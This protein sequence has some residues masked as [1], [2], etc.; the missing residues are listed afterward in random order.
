VRTGHCWHRCKVD[1]V[2]TLQKPISYHSITP[3]SY[4]AYAFKSNLV[5]LYICDWNYHWFY[6]GSTTCFSAEVAATIGLVE[7]HCGYGSGLSQ[8]QAGY[9]LLNDW[10]IGFGYQQLGVDGCPGLKGNHDGEGTNPSPV[11]LAQSLPQGGASSSSASQLPSSTPASAPPSVVASAS[12]VLPS[13]SL[14]AVAP[15][16][17]PPNVSAVFSGSAVASNVPAASS[18][19]A[20]SSLVAASSAPAASSFAS[21]S[22]S[23]GLL[24]VGY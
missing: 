6:T 8:V 1:R 7:N 14:G 18:F 19:A 23:V 24:P 15:S 9:Y 13:S 2:S 10:N 11:Y 22:V 3:F 5:F 4:T 12:G 17:T 21:A 16:S 20:T